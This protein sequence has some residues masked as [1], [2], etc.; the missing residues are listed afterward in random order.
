[1]PQTTQH[2]HL[3]AIDLMI[4]SEHES[5]DQASKVLVSG[6]RLILHDVTCVVLHTIHVSSA[7]ES[8]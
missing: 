8:V 4:V 2:W 7:Q 3:Y 5:D 1:M 6:K